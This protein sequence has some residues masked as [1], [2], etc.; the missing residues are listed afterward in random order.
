MAVRLGGCHLLGD[1][2]VCLVATHPP[3]VLVYLDAT[4]YVCNEAGVERVEFDNADP[5]RL[6]QSFPNSRERFLQQLFSDQASGG[7]CRRDERW[8]SETP[9]AVSSGP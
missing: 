5:V 3:S 7:R 2:L 1:G 4:I 8:G 6:T 9:T